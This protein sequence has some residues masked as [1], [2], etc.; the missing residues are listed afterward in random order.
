MKNKA[1]ILI[2]K[3]MSY[4]GVFTI[5][6]LA[7]QMDIGQPAISKWKINNS[8]HAIKKKC[9]ELG[10]YNEIFGDINTSFTQHG[11]GNQQIG[12]QNN[13]DSSSGASNNENIKKLFNIAYQELN[14]SDES[15]EDLSQEME[16]SDR[17]IKRVT[18][19]QE[20]YKK[21]KIKTIEMGIDE[22]GKFTP[23]TL[24]KAID[25]LINEIEELK[26]QLK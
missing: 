18:I 20:T 8:I 6:E 22:D 7:Q 5:S 16:S 13:L 24:G 2:D 4:Y 12:T 1:E 19:T 23:E 3:L 25:F 17:I 14:E 11:N 15:K 10:I 9:R 21:L 26:M